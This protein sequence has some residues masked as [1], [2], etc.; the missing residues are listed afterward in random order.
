[1]AAAQA[2][3]RL[4][5]PFPGR[6][7]DW[8]SAHGGAATYEPAEDPGVLAVKRMHSYYKAH[9]H[10]R[11][12][13][14]PASWRPSRGTADPKYAVDE[15]V[16]LAGVDRM[17]MPPALLAVL[18]AE[19]A[20][21]PRRLQPGAPAAAACAD[22]ALPPLTES[23]FRMALCED[24][25]ATAKLAEGINAFVAETLKLERALKERL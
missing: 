5:S 19:E 11:T 21:L 1:V 20:E 6:I 2:G 24:G 10:E 12:I 13:C 17:T 9:G 22:E 25:A 4:I 7:K 15:V 16:A 3:A 14:M 8:H 18:A 23:E